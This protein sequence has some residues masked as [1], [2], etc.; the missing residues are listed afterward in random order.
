M[1]IRQIAV[2]EQCLSKFAG[3]VEPASAFE[4]VLTVGGWL[5]PA[6]QFTT[7]SLNWV[8][9][10]ALAGW[11]FSFRASNSAHI[12]HIPAR[13]PW[14]SR[15]SVGCQPEIDNQ[16]WWPVSPAARA[17]PY[18]TPLCPASFRPFAVF[19]KTPS[20]RR[21]TCVSCRPCSPRRGS[22]GVFEIQ[23]AFPCSG[24]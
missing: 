23:H 20:V 13:L 19:R 12:A 4:C 18:H 8:A 7:N 1:I 17:R 2:Y 22:P 9:H 15:P 10:S 16:H 5:R 6:I 24:L 3:L 14:G 21:G 11:G